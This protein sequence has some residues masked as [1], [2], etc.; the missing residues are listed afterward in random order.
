MKHLSRRSLLKNA[1]LI[2]LTGGAQKSYGSLDPAATP[3]R[4]MFVFISGGAPER[5]WKKPCGDA[6]NSQYISTLPLHPWLPR[7][8]F[9]EDAIT[10][11]SGFEV[12]TRAALCTN[13]FS[14]SANSIDTQIARIKSDAPIPHLRLM[15]QS[16]NKNFVTDVTPTIVDGVYTSVDDYHYDPLSAFNELFS[17]QRPHREFAEFNADKI[18]DTFDWLADRQIELATM[19][20]QNELSNVVTL[21]LGDCYGNIV[22]P[23]LPDLPEQ[24]GWRS[25]NASNNPAGAVAFRNYLTSKWAYLLKLL[26]TTADATGTPLL[27]S[28]MVYFFTDEGESNNH[29]DIGGSYLLAGADDFFRHGQDPVYD[30]MDYSI[31]NTIAEAFLLP[32]QLADKYPVNKN[33]LRS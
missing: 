17:E 33:F 23:V 20:L 10:V 18:T 21:M 6:L 29:T 13:P 9:F 32:P 30:T 1:A 11:N 31:L 25:I 5:S 4:A 3:K 15:A 16:G 24:Y 22:N 2:S 28:T 8:T 7:C 19:A 26:A 27:N 14:G 12:G